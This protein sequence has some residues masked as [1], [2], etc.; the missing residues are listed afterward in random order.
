MSSPGD[1][2]IVTGTGP[3]VRLAVV[4]DEGVFVLSG[5]K[6]MLLRGRLYGLVTP[7]LDGKTPDE[8]A[9]MRF[10][11]PACGSGSFLLAVYDLLLRYHT[12]WYNRSRTFGPR[13]LD[14]PNEFR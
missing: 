2:E 14:T 11:D 9:R 5:A 7:L 6:Q 10:L 13:L 12:I 8:I 1:P 4:P 3:G